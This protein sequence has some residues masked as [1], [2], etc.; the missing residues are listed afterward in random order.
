MTTSLTDPMI[1]ISQTE[2]ESLIR[3]VVQETVRAELTRLLRKPNRFV[4]DSWLH[5]GPDGSEDDEELL[6]DALTLIEQYEK[7]PQ[8]WK[9]LEEFEVELAAVEAR[10]EL[11]S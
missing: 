6:A 8:G 5:E 9:S 10:H 4:L 11:P 1:V 2:L 3:R 7:A